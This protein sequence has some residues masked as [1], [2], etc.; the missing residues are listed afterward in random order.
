MRLPDS[1]RRDTHASHPDVGRYDHGR[2]DQL[3][4]DFRAANR[5]ERPFWRFVR[6]HPL[7]CFG[8][9]LLVMVAFMIVAMVHE[10]GLDRAILGGT[11]WRW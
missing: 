1:N 5:R 10:S 2:V 11:R 7:Y 6:D 3:T 9:V 4:I 8:L